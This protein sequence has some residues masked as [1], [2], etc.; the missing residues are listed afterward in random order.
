[1]FMSEYV[2]DRKA[3]EQNFHEVA[4]AAYNI[5][6]NNPEAVSAYSRSFNLKKDYQQRLKYAGLALDLNPSHA[7]SNFDYGLALCNEKNFA[8]AE[9]YIEKAIGLDP[10][11]SRRYEGFFP[12][13][14]MAM[15][16]SKQAM[17]WSN[18]ICE[19]N[20]HSRYDGFRAAICAHL[21]DLKLAKEYLEI[22]KS[23]RPEI[24]N[25]DDY[26]KISP[27]I[28]EKYLID[29]LEKIW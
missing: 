13:L 14:Y 10:I 5:D 22:F 28:C 17:L 6:A 27:S 26:K 21:G 25:L 11:G 2:N 29:G 23:K 19:R 18:L 12:M 20:Q 9:Q 15:Q 1:M 8:E 7:G 3:N 24:F 4:V 16:N